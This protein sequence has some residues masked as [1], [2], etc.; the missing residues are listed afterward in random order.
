MI[1]REP[2]KCIAAMRVHNTV[3][4]VACGYMSFGLVRVLWQSDALQIG[5]VQ[6]PNIFGFGQ[7]QSSDGEYYVLLHYLS[8]YLDFLDTVFIVLKK[9]DAQLS[10]L[11][12]YHHATIG[13]IWGLLLYIGWGSG[14][15][16]FGALL[17]SIVHV[18]M[19]THYL[20]ASFKIKNPF[21]SVLTAI[22][23]CQF[24]VCVLHSVLAVGL[25]VSITNY[26]RSISIWQ[27]VYHTSMI[28]LFTQFFNKSYRSAESKKKDN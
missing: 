19:Y 16:M 6:V 27:A 11:H 4:I 5:P 1:K 17:N 20:A 21:K 22:Q 26:P 9:K 24:Y 7:E 10:F 3:Q 8:K 28:V 18:L 12:V 13:P 14:T 23:I 15:P 2:M 25:P